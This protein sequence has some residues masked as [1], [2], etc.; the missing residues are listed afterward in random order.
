MGGYET[1]IETDREMFMTNVFPMQLVLV[2]TTLIS[3]SITEIHST[4]NTV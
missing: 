2:Y 4:V 3:T 1:N